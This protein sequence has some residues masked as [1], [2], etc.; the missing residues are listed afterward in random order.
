M[1]KIENYDINYL[2]KSL[3]RNRIFTQSQRVFPQILKNCKRRD[4]G[5]E[6]EKKIEKNCACHSAFMHVNAQ[7]TFLGVEVLSQRISAS[8]SYYPVTY[9]YIPLRSINAFPPPVYKRTCFSD[10][11]TKRMGLGFSTMWQVILI[12]CGCECGWESFRMFQGHRNSVK[13]HKQ[14]WWVPGLETAPWSSVV[15]IVNKKH[16]TGKYCL[17]LLVFIGV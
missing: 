14:I 17:C 8:L 7:N 11:L 9:C 13:P 2:I 5:K 6:K 12:F 1:N 16:W 3:L 10:S 4:G 15:C